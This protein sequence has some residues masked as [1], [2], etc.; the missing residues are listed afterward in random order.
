MTEST[1]NKPE[2]R[3][4]AA[5]GH[6]AQDID[7]FV[8]RM[9]A[10]LNAKAGEFDTERVGPGGAMLLLTLAEAETLPVLE[11]ARRLARDKAQISRTLQS[12]QTKG[13]VSR[14]SCESDARVGLVSLT[15]AGWRTVRRLRGALAET[16]DEL[17]APLG[18]K[19]R[20]TLELLMRRAVSHL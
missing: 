16:V 9:H 2:V 3:I 15:E 8:R 10:A 5:E 4:D 20:R 6:L 7:L 12:L 19:D 17:L 1:K 13:L 14:S 18:A 11:L